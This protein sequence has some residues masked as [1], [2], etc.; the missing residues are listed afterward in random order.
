MPE[1]VVSAPLVNC[2]KARLYKYWKNL[3]YE[4]Q[5]DM[6]T[7]LFTTEIAYGQWAK[8]VKK[9]QVWKIRTVLFPLP[10]L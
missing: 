10:S 4:T 5:E 8:W 7:K 2:F 6:F 3:M 9:V 1:E